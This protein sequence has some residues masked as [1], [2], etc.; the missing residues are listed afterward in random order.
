MH[1]T[2]DPYGVHRVRLIN[3]RLSNYK[4]LSLTLIEHQVS[5]RPG[6]QPSEDEA[7]SVSLQAV[8]IPL[9]SKI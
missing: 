8:M 3:A 2:G 1:R 5:S 6:I 4:T 7:V 9:K